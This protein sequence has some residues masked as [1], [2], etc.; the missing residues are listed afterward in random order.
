MAKRIDK[1]IIRKLKAYVKELSRHYKIEVAILFGSY[2]KGSQ[3]QDSDI[4]IAIISKDVVD[5]FSDGVKMM[6]YR[7]S[8]DLRIEPHPISLKDYQENATA[9]TNEIIKTGIRVA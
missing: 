4:D 6:Q 5:S 3:H 2:A 8:I 1:S 9:L 7:R